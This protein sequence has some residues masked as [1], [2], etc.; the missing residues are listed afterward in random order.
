[1]KFAVIVAMVAGVLLGRMTCMLFPAPR[2]TAEPVAKCLPPM[3][4]PKQ[5]AKLV[6]AQPI[7]CEATM[8][9]SVAE[10]VVHDGCYVRPENRR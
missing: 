10:I 6:L 5:G 8:R 1:M 7:P 4:L 3:P 9:L 2:V